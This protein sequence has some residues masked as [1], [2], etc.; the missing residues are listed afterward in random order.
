MENKPEEDYRV[1]GNEAFK[2][3]KWGLAIKHYTKGIQAD[4]QN[5]LLFSNRSAAW[6]KMN[7]DNKALEDAEAC[8]K[9]QPQWAKGYYRKGCALREMQ[10]DHDALQALQRAVELAPKDGEIRGKFTEV[11]LRVKEKDA[12]KLLTVEEGASDYEQFKS[13]LKNKTPVPYSEEACLDFGRKK[14]HNVKTTVLGGEPIKPTAYYLFG[15]HENIGHS[16][17]QKQGVASIDAVFQSPDTHGSCIRFLRKYGEDMNAHAV[18]IIADKSSIA[19]PLVWRSKSW[20]YE[21]SDGIFIQLETKTVRR[22]WFLPV[23]RPSHQQQQQ[24]SNTK[25]HAQIANEEDLDIEEYALFPRLL[26]EEAHKPSNAP[27]TA[28]PPVVASKNSNNSNNTK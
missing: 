14:L 18:C 10:R 24:Q 26:L 9:L 12:H 20:K 23:T 1:L 22:L 11:L 4:P 5:H 2:S 6:M 15:Y 3:A 7:K 28:T 21:E 8:I 19:F 13:V 17:E 25:R 16:G 27:M